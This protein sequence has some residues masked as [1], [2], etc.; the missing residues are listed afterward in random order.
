[1]LPNPEPSA[2]EPA[3]VS[4]VF[5]VTTTVATPEDARRLA[6]AVLQARLAACVQVLPITSHYRWQ[7][8]LH[9]DAE[10]RI[11]CKTTAAAVAPLL[12]LLRAQ[13]P[14]T[15]AQLVA[16]PL[17]ASADYARWVAEEVADQGAQEPAENRQVI[18]PLPPGPDA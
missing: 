13:H 16:Q 11:D 3:P 15:L 4:T 5:L 14:Y 10:Q 17:Q 12:A 2:P 8:A 18:G 9:E 7:G 6:Q 1:M